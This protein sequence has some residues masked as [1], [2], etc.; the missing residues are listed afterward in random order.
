MRLPEDLEPRAVWRWFERLSEIPRP[1]GHEEAVADMLVRFA[2]ERGLEHERDAADNVLIRRPGTGEAAGGR[3]VA[4]QAHVDMVPEKTDGSTHDFLTDPIPLELDGDRVV[5]RETTLGAD[6]G[7][8]VALMLALLE[9]D[10]I[11]HPPLECLFT[12]DEERGLTGAAAL[13]PGWLRSERLINLDSEDERAFCIGCAGGLDMEVEVPLERTAGS[14]QAARLTV[15]GLSGGHSGMEI[16]ESRANALRIL[17]RVLWRLREEHGCLVADLSGGTK[18]NAIP[19]SASAEL[20]LPGGIESAGGTVSVVA[21]DLSREYEGIED[22]MTV[23]LLESEDCVPPPLSGA[24][25]ERIVAMLLALPHGVEKMSGV[26][27]GLVETSCN[28]AVAGMTEDALELTLSVRSPMVSAKC[29]MRD[30][31][32]AV[33]RL[34]GGSLE[35]GGSYPGWLPDPSSRLLAAASDAY[36]EFYG[37]DPV[38]VSIHAGLECGIIGDRMGGLDMI[39]VGPDIR[40][41]HVPGESVSVPSVAGFWGFLTVLLA[42][43]GRD[44]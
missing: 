34:A 4:L 24:C 7:I 30:R 36:G 28:L 43:L 29:A 33:V 16:G 8:G 12:T 27:D 40:D 3:S 20:V 38:V 42:R 10:D 6:N 14:G 18:R 25:C 35:T 11:S 41:V 23:S 44:G 37:R 31:V 19:R 22:S 26:V 32:D 17:G 2:V 9:T 39:S 5:S 21:E 1:S 15:S 13:S